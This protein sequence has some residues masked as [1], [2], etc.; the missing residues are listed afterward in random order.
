MSPMGTMVPRMK[1]KMLPIGTK[2]GTIVPKMK[3]II[4]HFVLKKSR[5]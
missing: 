4:L 5:I 3:P 2:M 1:V